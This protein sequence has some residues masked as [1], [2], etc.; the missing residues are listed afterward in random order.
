MALA[1]A[2]LAGGGFMDS[3]LGLERAGQ[4]VVALDER[5][6]EGFAPTPL[7]ARTEQR[8]D[9]LALALYARSAPPADGGAPVFAEVS[10]VVVPAARSLER[11]VPF[12]HA[13]EPAL[14]VVGVG[15]EPDEQAVGI[16]IVGPGPKVL[17]RTSG[18][19]GPVPPG[20]VL[21][22]AP[23]PEGFQLADGGGELTAAFA[24]KWIPLEGRDGG[25]ALSV[26]ETVQRFT[27]GEPSR[28]PEPAHFESFLVPL[29]AAPL[30][31][32]RHAIDLGAESPVRALEV[33]GAALDAVVLEGQPP[34]PFDAA[35]HT[36]DARVYGAAHVREHGA[37]ARTK[38]LVV[39]DPPVSA[40]QLRAS[41]AGK[42]LACTAYRTAP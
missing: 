7:L 13:G 20:P 19:R 14:A 37:H 21:D 5:W 33:E 2:P 42:G 25:A 22:L 36:A 9:T 4:G 24:R 35:L 1:A 12:A 18:L 23:A 15:E 29:R 8:G 10:R 26:G 32:E 3:A 39:F 27:L 31:T 6:V 16:A 38:I 28:P 30:K 11:V 40:R 34:I 17:L 41:A